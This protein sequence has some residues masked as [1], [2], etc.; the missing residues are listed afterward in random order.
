[1]ER[2]RIN[3][4][5]KSR[6]IQQRN[7][8]NTTYMVDN[9]SDRKH[10]YLS[11]S[12]LQR[13]NVEEEESL[14]GKFATP[15]Q[16]V[17]DEDDTMQ[18]KLDR[19]ILKKNEAGMPDNLKAGIE[20][21][22]GFSMADVRVHY[23]SSKPA[24][25]QALAY[26]QG[27][28]IHIAPGQE[29]HLPHEAWHVAQQKAG[30]VSPTTSINGMPVNDNAG[31]EHEAEIMG[32]IAVGQRKKTTEFNERVYGEVD[33]DFSVLPQNGMNSKTI[34]RVNIE[35]DGNSDD[36]FKKELNIA[37]DQLDTELYVK[38]IKNA[39]YLN[40]S[41]KI[42]ENETAKS[43]DYTMKGNG[44][45]CPDNWGDI[46][47]RKGSESQ[48]QGGGRADDN[49]LLL[50]MN[51]EQCTNMIFGT[52][53]TKK[54]QT[55]ASVLLHELGHAYQHYLRILNQTVDN[56]NV[57]KYPLLFEAIEK[58][59]IDP[60]YQERLDTALR[61]NGFK[62]VNYKNIEDN[63]DDIMKKI[64]EMGD[65]AAR[66]QDDGDN[67]FMNEILYNT[68]HDLSVR[69]Q[70]KDVIDKRFNEFLKEASPYII[71][72]GQMPKVKLEGTNEEKIKQLKKIQDAAI[73]NE[74]FLSDSYFVMWFSYVDVYVNIWNDIMTKNKDDFKELSSYISDFYQYVSCE[75]LNIYEKLNTLRKKFIKNGYLKV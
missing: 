26:T 47:I 53:L 38:S 68:K 66:A 39:K 1:M 65:G 25:V 10:N 50:E 8:Y 22:S 44:D 11:I 24:T 74:V 2:E 41:G 51:V 14:Q 57:K 12:P 75:S 64:S 29:K 5:K 36:S 32:K 59:K 9:R 56:E 34:Q 17:E 45:T 18:G 21:I 43:D 23:N 62:D 55:V 61:L 42:V 33:H 48:F 3:S 58:S 49:H 6:I 7:K 27:T 16:R 60:D 70:Y 69:N 72:E 54:T 28:D 63:I 19:P 35:V 67:I 4:E 30:R 13:I 46:L 73:K 37:L 52:D 15:I 31:L 40:A 20:S 71:I